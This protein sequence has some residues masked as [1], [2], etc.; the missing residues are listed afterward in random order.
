MTQ[1]CVSLNLSLGPGDDVKDAASQSGKRGLGFDFGIEVDG[2]Y[3]ENDV[4]G[5]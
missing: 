1:T 4:G 5:G 2:L 3:H